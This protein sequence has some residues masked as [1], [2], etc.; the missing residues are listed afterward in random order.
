MK[1]AVTL[2]VA[3]YS[4]AHAAVEF[5]GTCASVEDC[6]VPE[7]PPYYY[8]WT[9]K[10]TSMYYL[11][12][13]AYLQSTLVPAIYTLQVYNDLKK[14]KGGKKPKSKDVFDAAKDP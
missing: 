6:G 10:P 9:Y 13:V 8:D 11:T 14:A 2:L 5:K 3:F 12:K 1:S 4:A 7:D